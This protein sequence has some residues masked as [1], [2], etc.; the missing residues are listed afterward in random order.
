MRVSFLKYNNRHPWRVCAVFDSALFSCIDVDS[1][2]N[3]SI[4]V[5]FLTRWSEWR[6]FGMCLR[7]FCMSAIFE[8]LDAFVCDGFLRSL[9]FNLAWKFLS[10]ERS[11]KTDSN[12][13]NGDSIWLHS[14]QSRTIYGVYWKSQPVTH[15]W[16]STYSNWWSVKMV[17]QTQS[18]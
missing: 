5:F 13:E 16:S 18:A 11:N 3:N 17:G 7:L 12:L 4:R 10:S 15:R 9:W 14:F 8:Y 2:I 1:P 6:R